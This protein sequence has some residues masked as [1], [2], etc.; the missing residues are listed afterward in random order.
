MTDSGLLD[1]VTQQFI[2]ALHRDTRYIHLAAKHLF[3]YL[4]LIQLTLTALWMTLA[5][6][7]LQ[8]FIVKLVQLLFS[9]GFFYA[10]IENGGVW[11]PSLING[12][13]ELGQQGGV[14]SLDPSSIVSQGMSISGAI[15]KAFF[16]L[17]LLAHPFVSLV[18]AIVCI[19]LLILY[20]LMAAEL[21][22][23]LVKSYIVVSLGGLFFAFGAS[24]YTRQ[25]MMRYFQ[26]A[27]GLGLQ[28]M[29]LYFL[30]GVGQHIGQDWAT[31]TANAAKQHELMPMLMILCSVIVY[32]MILK[33]IPVFIASFSGV[34]GFRNYGDTAVGMAINAGINGSR[35]LSRGMGKMGSV[36]QGL[37]QLGAT[38]MHAAKSLHGPLSFS[39][40]LAQMGKH[41]AGAGQQAVRDAVMQRNTHLS[42]GQRLNHHLANRLKAKSNNPESS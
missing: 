11:I 42:F 38:G 9:F 15:F 7:S 16:G 23:V 34:G 24:D 28:L 32:Y 18:G 31:M 27:I 36:T 22:L 40:N 33:N 14:Q 3:Y 25:M 5:G 30:L 29:T 13:I 21:T 35:L 12:F 1:Q 39:K 10:L 26:S 41:L 8:R 20:G 6:E 4:A 37:G 2:N 17:G 19:A